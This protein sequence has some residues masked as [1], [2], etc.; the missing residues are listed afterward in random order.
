MDYDNDLYGKLKQHNIQD[1]LYLT[2]T[3]AYN[4]NVDLL[5]KTWMRAFACLCQYTGVCFIKLYDTAKDIVVF[6]ENDAIDVS[7]LF[8][9]TIKLA[10]LFKNSDQY[11]VFPKSTI[12]QL[13]EKTIV[14][15]SESASHD[16]YFETILPKPINEKE[17]CSKIVGALVRLW[18]KG[19]ATNL[20]DTLEYLCRKDYVID[21]L[22]SETESNITSFI[23][24]FFKV[25][26]PEVATPFYTLYKTDFKKKEKSWRNN[27]LYALHNHQIS[28]YAT[29][30]WTIEE[31]RMIERTHTI[32]KEIWNYVI[33]ENTESNP[34][35]T[36]CIEKQHSD[37]VF[38]TYMPRRVDD[39]RDG[40]VAYYPCSEADIKVV[41][42]KSKKDKA[43][44]KA[45]R[46][47]KAEKGNDDFYNWKY[48]E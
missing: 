5:F 6:I 24:D 22:H 14:F 21:S 25:F 36:K 27:F 46:S 20:R 12:T 30:N 38:D 47:A 8:K 42:L 11:T 43:K 48:M 34:Q 19:E 4:E 18:A 1:A 39:I 45:I 3:L 40:G 17:F 23:W 28:G 29:V 35:T 31:S 16:A 33:A 32:S 9:I 26:K 2:G 37:D 7:H 44:R 15:F 10:I 41:S 13:R